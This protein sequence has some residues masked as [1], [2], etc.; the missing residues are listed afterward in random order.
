[1]LKKNSICNSDIGPIKKKKKLLVNERLEICSLLLDQ[2]NSVFTSPI[3]NMI[4][5]D[6]VS[7]FSCQSLNP[8]E[9][10]T[11]IEITEQIIIDSIH[12]LPSTSAA[13]PDGVPSYLLLKCADQLA[14]AL[15]LM[16]SQSLTHVCFIPSSFKRAAITLVFKSGTKTSPSNYRPIS[17]T[18]TIIKVFEQIIRKQVVAFMNRQGHLNN[19][20]HGFRSGRSC[21]SALLDVFDDLM[22]MLSSDTTVDMIYLDF[23]KA[24]DKV[25][26]GVLLHKLKDLG[27]TGKFG[28]W[29]F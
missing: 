3:T 13:G 11:D 4:V 26:H 29:C 2:F 14:T 8:D 9:C 23:L 15:K 18:S 20:H 25:D 21:L 17:L 12:E 1:M 28:I 16:F 24:F 22:H 5:C 6:P 27:I 7:F 10:L 19:T